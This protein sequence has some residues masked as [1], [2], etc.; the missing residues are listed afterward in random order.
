MTL[1]FFLSADIQEFGS[2]LIYEKPIEHVIEQSYRDGHDGEVEIVV[3]TSKMLQQRNPPYVYQ[4]GK[5]GYQQK[6]EQQFVIPVFEDQYPIS[7]EVE[8]DADNRRE[9][10]GDNIGAVEQKQMFEDKQ[11]D[12]VDEQT[13]R[14]VQCGDQYKPYE[15]GLEISF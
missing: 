5:C 9:E 14:R 12:I 10:V 1:V 4:I 11:E 6:S 8:Q 3:L 13:E 7:L 15:L 2:L